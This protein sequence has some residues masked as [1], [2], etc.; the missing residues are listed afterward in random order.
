MQI[1]GGL[2]KL[3]IYCVPEGDHYDP[4]GGKFNSVG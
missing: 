3:S 1:E 2:S 4:V